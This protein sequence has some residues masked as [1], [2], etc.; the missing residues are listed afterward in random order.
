MEIPK[1]AFGLRLFTSKIN[2]E[3]EDYILVLMLKT[4]GTTIAVA[5]VLP[6]LIYIDE[7]VA[8][9]L[10]LALTNEFV[11]YF[12]LYSRKTVVNST[13]TALNFNCMYSCFSVMLIFR[14]KVVPSTGTYINELLVL[15][16]D[17]GL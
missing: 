3:A 1:S 9:L 2:T 7:L 6:H 4:L 15:L 8:A 13:R 17:V 5:L 10:T 12:K 14:V 16:L 11:F